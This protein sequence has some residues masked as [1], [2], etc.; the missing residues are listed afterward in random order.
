LINRAANLAIE[1]GLVPI[2]VSLRKN[3]LDLFAD[4]QCNNS[5]AIDT[6]YLIGSGP[7]LP[8]FT[9]W[10]SDWSSSQVTIKYFESTSAQAKSQL[11][12][13]DEEFGTT[14]NGVE[15]QWFSSIPD[16]TF[17]PAAVF[18]MVPSTPL[19]LRRPSLFITHSLSLTHSFTHTRNAGGNRLQLGRA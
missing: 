9:A 2:D 7:P 14:M 17:A 8:I 5:P 6:S 19:L 11:L 10:S 3:L 16:L 1:N 15:A 13:F 18:G 12:T 4:I